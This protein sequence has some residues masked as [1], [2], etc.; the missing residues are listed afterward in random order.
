MGVEVV[1][2]VSNSDRL[3]RKLEMRIEILGLM[4][5]DGCYIDAFAP[6]GKLSTITV[7][8]V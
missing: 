5:G 3:L 7:T 6:V 4:G 1:M 2:M 8:Q